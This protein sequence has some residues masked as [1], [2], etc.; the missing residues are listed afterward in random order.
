MGVLDFLDA[1]KRKEKRLARSIR[2]ANSKYKPKDHRQIALSEVIEA[3]KQGNE[4]AIG[5]LLARFGVQAEPSTE[6]EREKE[7][8][9][10]ALV[11]IDR[12][13]LNQIKQAMRT[14]EGVNW[15]HRT[16]KNIVPEDEYRRE[17]LDVL[18][19]FD[20]EYERNPDRK[21]QTIMALA[22]VSG[23]EIPGALLRFLKDVD[24][25]VRF[26]TVVT[27]AKH[28]SELAR[29]PLL[30]TMCSDESIRVRNEAVAAF[31]ELGWLVKGY[32]KKVEAILPPTHKL[33]KSGKIVKLGKY[34]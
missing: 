13:A 30:E 23:E 27:L 14:A 16:F 3:A 28:G 8:V 12:K 31:G 18:S 5:G 15:I 34:N 1:E 11:Q 29:E 19:D 24:E 7:W 21:L 33:D 22:D 9:F 26:Q 10:D 20:T 6:D 4:V 25:T 2:S 32:R 17:L